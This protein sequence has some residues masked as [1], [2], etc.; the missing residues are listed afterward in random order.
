MTIFKKTLSLFIISILVLS[1][2]FFVDANYND[3]SR[4]RDITREE[5]FIFIWQRLLQDI[6]P[7]Y[8]YIELNYKDVNKNTKIYDSFQ[9][10]V[11]FDIIKNIN[12]NIWLDK[13]LN[14]YIFY[15]LSSHILDRDLINEFSLKNL[16]SRNS[17]IWDLLLI[18]EFLKKENN[19]LI[20]DIR[21]EKEIL[22]LLTREDKTRFEIFLDVYRTILSSHYDRADFNR[23]DMINAA[24]NWMLES[25]NDPYT[26]YFPPREASDFIESFSW[27]FEWIWAYVE[28]E[29][30]WDFRII[31]PLSDSPAFR[32]WLRWWDLIIEVDWFEITKDISLKEAVSR[33]RWPAWTT[34]NLKI[35]RWDEIFSVDVIRAKVSIKDVEYKELEN[36]FF[37]IQI[38]MFWDNVFSQFKEAL[39]ALNKS[40]SKKVIFD[41]RNNPG[42]YLESVVDMLSL[43]IEEGKP[44]ALVNYLNWQVYYNSKWYDL[45][46]L[47]N[48]E[49]YV[50]QNSW[51]ASASEIMIWALRDYY[52]ITSIWE[53]T[54]WKWSVQ[55][56]REYITW[57]TLK[58]T[59]ARWYTW[60]T[61]TKVDVVWIEA[62]VEIELTKE[63]IKN[64][65]DTQLD[66]ILKNY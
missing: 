47:S 14:A 15:K 53:K 59:V 64:N 38:K 57:S 36:W 4:Y 54:F 32:A 6:P 37:L 21:Y 56:L 22:W 7:S 49:I 33:V 12:T 29:T 62:D 34:V 10:L 18:E 60:L 24:I 26:T 42:W 51:S 1:N 58:Y 2:I 8:K 16:K 45:I 28:M 31:S 9:R 63:D 39:E 41:L 19:L 48:Y 50:L 46:D 20:D 27:E 3:I 17:N 43:F 55:T 40:N 66:Y 35:K 61:K 11:Y 5:A 65:I 13:T 44:L 52:D 30:P 25:I 23:D